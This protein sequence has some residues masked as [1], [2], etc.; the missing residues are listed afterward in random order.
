VPWNA[1]CGVP[2]IAGLIAAVIFSIVGAWSDTVGLLL[3]AVIYTAGVWLMRGISAEEI[4]A[5]PSLIAA[6]LHTRQRAL[7]Q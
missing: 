7:D 2:I 3:A 6:V 5:I 1:R 4:K